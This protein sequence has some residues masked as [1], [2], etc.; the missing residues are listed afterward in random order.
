MGLF[1]TA[2]VSSFPRRRESNF[3]LRML[4]EGS[5][6]S[7][8]AGMTIVLAL[9][10][11]QCS[12]SFA[13]DS[14]PAIGSAATDQTAAVDATAFEDVKRVLVVGDEMGGGMGGGLTRMTAN[15]LNF[16]IVNRY[17]EAS[18]LARPDRYDWATSIPKIMEGKNFS[19]A[20]VLIGLNDR[21]D[22]RTPTGRLTFNSPEWLV[23]YKANVDALIDA[24]LAQDVKV[25][26]LG[27]PPMGDPAYDADMQMISTLQKERALAKGIKFVDLRTPFLGADGLYSARGPDDSGIDQKL[28]QND[29]VTFFRLG[30]NRIGQ[31]VLQALK[32]NAVA[33]AAEIV[34]V[35]PG[36]DDA[37]IPPASEEAGPVFAQED[38]NGQAVLHSGGDV[39]ALVANENANAAAITASSIG[40]AASAG[41]S[42]ERMFTVGVSPV[43][44]AGRFDDFTYTPPAP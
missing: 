20:V 35:A 14:L 15:D 22:I 11:A 32:D 12:Y 24:L 21:Q 30:N 2:F 43:A 39:I 13:Q 6:V 41:S 29:G 23:A 16:E 33:P 42:A 36:K 25:V 38:Q 37:A 8:C 5:W 27:L 7:A 9:L 28:R 3:E 19:T 1:N 10:T 31:I 34:T 17:S 44:P 40:V 4:L 26:W 18:A